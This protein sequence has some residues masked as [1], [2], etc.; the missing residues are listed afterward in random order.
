MLLLK[1]VLFT[2]PTTSLSR[3]TLEYQMLGSPAIHFFR[4]ISNSPSLFQTLCL[5]SSVSFSTLLCFLDTSILHLNKIKL[6]SLSSSIDWVPC[7][8]FRCQNS[9][10]SNKFV[11]TFPFS[12]SNLP[13]P[14]C[15]LLS[16][17]LLLH[18]SQVNLIY[19][20]QKNQIKDY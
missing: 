19:L 11:D 16:L 6:K 14:V 15:F 2:S 10:V 12:F 3:S 1:M 18:R 5:F 9:I 4:Y 17:L 8:V 20:V 7:F 13:F